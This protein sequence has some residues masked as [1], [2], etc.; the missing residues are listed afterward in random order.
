M[1]EQ[2]LRLLGEGSEEDLRRFA[3]Q[4]VELLGRGPPSPSGQSFFSYRVLR[5][6]SPDTLVSQ[7][8]AGL[9]AGEE[10]GGLREQV[11]RQTVRERLAF[12]RAGERPARPCASAW[13]ACV[14]P[15]RPRCGAGPR[16]RRA[17][18][19]SPGAPC[20]RWPTR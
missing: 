15:A 2:L 5:A 12:V 9:L 6:L 18:T 14:R 3:R 16:P 11:A 17:G 1:R 7:L 20:A 13:P 4:A 8:L 19:R 10:R